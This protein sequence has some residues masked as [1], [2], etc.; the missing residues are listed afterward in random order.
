MVIINPQQVDVQVL[1][2]AV[3]K[4]GYPTFQKSLE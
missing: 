3:A 1:I 2:D 4:I